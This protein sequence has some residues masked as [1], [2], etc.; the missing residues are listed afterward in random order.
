MAELTPIGA[1][2]ANLAAS[3]A[4]PNFA[5]QFNQIQNTII[6]RVNDEIARVNE[7]GASIYSASEIARLRRLI[8]Q[9]EPWGSFSRAQMDDLA[10]SGI[11][12]LLGS[13]LENQLPELP[14]GAV[15]REISRTGKTVNFAV[16]ASAGAACHSDTVEISH[17]L[18]DFD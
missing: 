4:Q 2:L 15:L 6:R 12:V 9:L 11:Q 14:D 18:T 17:V 5:L 10:A 7:S 8:Q 13:A 16:A 3:A 1:T